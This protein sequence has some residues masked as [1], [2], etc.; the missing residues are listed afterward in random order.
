MFTGF[1]PEASDFFWELC[2]NNDRAWFYEH[3]DQFDELINEPL[4]SL[5]TETNKI[6]ASRFPEMHP[7]T[8]VSRIWRDA[9]RLFGRGPLKESM[10]FSMRGGTDRAFPASFYF[11]IKPAVFGYGMGFWC[12]TSEQGERFRKSVDADPARFIR[13]AEEVSAQDRFTLEGPL[14]KKPKGS[15]SEIA[16]GWYNRKW[17][18]LTYEENF[19]GDALSP[20]LPQ[21]LADAFSPLMPM[22]DYLNSAI[23]E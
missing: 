15:Y 12:A 23:G 6:M 13:I 2:F 7:V 4:K 8:H 19:E 10:W 22:Y 17:A 5:A 20:E 16:D 18:S 9:R 14:Y 3:K 21:I 1:K 11:E